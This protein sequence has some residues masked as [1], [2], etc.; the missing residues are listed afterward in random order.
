M[1]LPPSA[2]ARSARCGQKGCNTTYRNIRPGR[3][4]APAFCVCGRPPVRSGSSSRACATVKIGQASR[5]ASSKRRRVSCSSLSFSW[6]ITMTLLVVLTVSCDG[7]S[8]YCPGD[9][10]SR[11]HLRTS[12][13]LRTAVASCFWLC[14]ACSA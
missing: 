8:P 2:I 9:W 13:A 11:V 3:R 12:T 4:G 6:D 7:V 1:K 5:C 10:L 14:T